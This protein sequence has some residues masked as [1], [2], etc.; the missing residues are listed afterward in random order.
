MTSLVCKQTRSSPLFANFFVNLSKCMPDQQCV[1]HINVTNLKK[2]F[3]AFDNNV[4]EPEVYLPGAGSDHASFI[5]FAGVPVI[6]T[7]FDPVS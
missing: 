4:L 2:Y 3:K 7:S 5:F 1:R 6:D